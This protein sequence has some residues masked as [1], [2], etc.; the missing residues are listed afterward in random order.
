MIAGC[1]IYVLTVSFFGGK[2]CL[3]WSF[4]GNPDIKGRWLKLESLLF[5]KEWNPKAPP[6]FPLWS[7]R[8]FC[9]APRFLKASSANH[10]IP[11][12]WVCSVIAS[13]KYWHISKEESSLERTWPASWCIS[14]H[15]NCWDCLKMVQSLSST[16]SKYFLCSKCGHFDMSSRLVGFSF[17][18]VLDLLSSGHVEL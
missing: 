6:L 8:H 12:S 11:W 17:E 9:R 7:L 10:W 14:C 2:A 5:K 13:Q 15:K 4:W 18:H 3:K 16:S 1:G